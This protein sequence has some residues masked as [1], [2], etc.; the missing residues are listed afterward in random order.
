MW[1]SLFGTTR[2]DE[3]KLKEQ[4]QQV[5]EMV[6]AHLNEINLILEDATSYQ[7]NIICSQIFVC[8]LDEV[9]KRVIKYFGDHGW[10]I[11]FNHFAPIS[12]KTNTPTLVQY[13]IDLENS[14]A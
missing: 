9:P 10:L 4:N 14:G 2:K 13:F 11:R 12:A 5:E 3:L 7:L 6:S 1:F 8:S